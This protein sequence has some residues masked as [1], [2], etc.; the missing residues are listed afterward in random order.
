MTSPASK[1]VS[2]VM[3][4]LVQVD[5]PPILRVR[6]EE[7]W[8]HLQSLAAA[9]IESGLGEE[10]TREVIAAALDSFKDELSRTIIELRSQANG[11]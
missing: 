9:L 3:R 2:D 8:A 10:Q 1:V 7:H 5:L 6:L 4:P 11:H